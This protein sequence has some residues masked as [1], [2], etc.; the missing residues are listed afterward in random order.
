[1]T[2]KTYL[3]SRAALVLESLKA[4]ADDLRT[5]DNALVQREQLVA[6][7]NNRQADIELD[8]RRVLGKKVL[9]ELEQDDMDSAKAMGLLARSLREGRMDDADKYFAA[10]RIRELMQ[11]EEDAER[12]ARKPAGKQTGDATAG[13]LVVIFVFFLIGVITLLGSA[14]T[15]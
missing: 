11:E 9:D 10:K 15:G 4:W 8:E 2:L 3:F 6:E 13:F 1:M 5:K 7:E 12:L 14:L